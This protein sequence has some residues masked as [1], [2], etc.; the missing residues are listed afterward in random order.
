MHAP[1]RPF[2]PAAFRHR[3]WRLPAMPAIYLAIPDSGATVAGRRSDHRVWNATRE[4]A[5][6]RP[7]PRQPRRC[8][9]TLCTIAAIA[10]APCVAAN[11]P[12]FTSHPQNDFFRHGAMPLAGAEAALAAVNDLRS[13]KFFQLVI[14]AG[15]Y[16][17]ANYF[18]FSSNNPGTRMLETVVLPEL[19]AHVML[20]DLC[21]Q[22]AWAGSRPASMCEWHPCRTD[23]PPSLP[24]RRLLGRPLPFP[25]HHG[26]DGCRHVVRLRRPVR[27]P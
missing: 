8:S 7:R 14:V 19:G 21:V 26:G 12:A 3:R 27:P 15:Q 11:T 23:V 9:L 17:P 18:A 25:P 6:R 10:V 20:P 2:P 4:A 13:R 1:C 16:R 24:A 22:G 5:A